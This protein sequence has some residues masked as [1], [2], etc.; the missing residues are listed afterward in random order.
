MTYISY[1]FAL[2]HI[3]HHSYTKQFILQ[4]IP[5]CNTQHKNAPEDGLSKSEE[6][7]NVMNKI[8]H[9]ILCIFLD[10]TYIAE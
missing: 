8:N 10:Y 1:N 2:T 9:Q 4:D 3:K 6:L 5:N 7:L